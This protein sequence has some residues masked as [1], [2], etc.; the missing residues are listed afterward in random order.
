MHEF[1]VQA[2]LGSVAVAVSLSNLSRATVGPQQLFFTPN[3]W[4]VPQLVRTAAA[5]I[6]VLIP[7]SIPFMHAS[8]I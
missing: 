5:V 4:S 2:P 8:F 3:N 6:H 7:S 1:D